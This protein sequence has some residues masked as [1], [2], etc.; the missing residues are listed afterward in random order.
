M[1]QLTL[2]AKKLPNKNVQIQDADG[3]V[4]CEW[5]WH[6]SSCPTRRNKYVMYNCYRY[7]LEWL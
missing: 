7:K 5:P 1:E 3:N 4:K 2:Y 6:Y